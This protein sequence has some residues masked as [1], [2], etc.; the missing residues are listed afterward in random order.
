MN[1][2][3]IYEVS[4]QIIMNSGEARS[5]AMESIAEAK[6]GNI[7]NA[8]NLLTQA[9]E[10]INYFIGIDIGGTNLRAAILNEDYV[11]VDKI[12]IKNNVLDG[13]EKNLLNLINC[14]NEKWSNYDFASIGIG[15]PGPLNIKEGIILNPPN[16][17]SWE[18][19]NIKKFFEEKLKKP[20][21]V[22]N[23]AN[24]AAYSEAIIGAGKGKESVYYITLS[25]GVG[26]GFIYKGEIVNGFNSMAA[27]ICNMI[28]NEDEYSHSGLNKGGL[29]G[30]C[31]G[32]AIS[33]IASKINNK[34]ISTEEVFTEAKKVNKEYKSI[35]DTWVVNVSKAIANIISVVDPEIIVLGGSVILNNSSYLENII[36][37]VEK[38]VFKQTKVNIKLAEI[39]DDTGLIG[40]GIL[41]SSCILK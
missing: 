8:R 28:I 36:S 27:E 2:D 31:S 34:K 15:C 14:I 20:V 1:K 9:R 6:K 16:L 12:K 29:E 24:V 3:Q 4:F 32:T 5:M 13:P 41:A 35:L 18:N 19:F 17:K 30:Q 39:G 23:D 37:E 21:I 33:R 40:S 38:R 26:G 10:E 25:T 11:I 22:N 7:E